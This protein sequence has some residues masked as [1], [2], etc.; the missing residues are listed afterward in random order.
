MAADLLKARRVAN[1]VRDYYA[2]N[3]RPVQIRKIVDEKGFEIETDAEKV[4]QYAADNF[5]A[6]FDIKSNTIFIPIEINKMRY[7]RYAFSLAHEL[8]HYFLRHQAGEN[9]FFL[10]HTEDREHNSKNQEKEAN[11]FAAEL[12]AP[13]DEVR[14]EFE[15]NRSIG[16]IA[17]NFGVSQRVIQAQISKIGYGFI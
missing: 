3:E 15:K 12:L 5:D 6:L 7:S 16:N 17:K 2:L 4:M 9:G 8:G 13:V 1:K 11:E 10:R 14:A